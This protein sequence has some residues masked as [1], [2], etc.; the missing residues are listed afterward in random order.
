[1]LMLGKGRWVVLMNSVSKEHT[2]LSLIPPEVNEYQDWR[3]RWIE[4][5]SY[6]NINSNS[7]PIVSISAMQ[8]GRALERLIREVVIADP[9]LGTIYVLKADVSVGFYRI[10]L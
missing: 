5:Y 10:A 1:M 8:Y 6:S 7:L 2:E 3:P 4:K 9:F